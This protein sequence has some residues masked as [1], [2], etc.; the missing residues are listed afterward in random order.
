MHSM[1]ECF[2]LPRVLFSLVHET[3]SVHE[4]QTA[5]GGQ[6]IYKGDAFRAEHSFIPSTQSSQ[7]RPAKALTNCQAVQSISH[8]VRTV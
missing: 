7:T 5:L 6:L 1:L 8:V 3:L 2:S 4:K